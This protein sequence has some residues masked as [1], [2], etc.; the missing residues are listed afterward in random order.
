VPV[1]DNAHIPFYICMMLWEHPDIFSKAA[2]VSP[3][4]KVSHIDYTKTVR[5]K[6]LPSVPLLIYIDNGNDGL[7]SWRY[8]E[9]FW[10]IQ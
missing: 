4:L 6:A 5:E 2:C 3:A 8:L 1:Y 9:L 7:E 10:G